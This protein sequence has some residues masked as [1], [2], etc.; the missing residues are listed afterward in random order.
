MDR[1]AW[2]IATWFG[3]GLAPGA[4]GT[5]G[6][7][8]GWLLAVAAAWLWSWGRAELMIATWAL[9]G[10]AVWA[11]HRLAAATGN[12]DPQQVVVDEVAGVWL[13]LWGATAYNWKSAIL[14]LLLFRLFDIWKPP[15]ARQLEK[16][17]GGFGIVA[18]DLAAGVWAALVLRGAGWFN[19]Y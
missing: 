9:L 8:A 5:A 19:L 13:T 2:W 1:L 3:S 10:P 12:H 16:L 11:A 15:P 6:S 17:P 18:D 7:I 4:P 14:A